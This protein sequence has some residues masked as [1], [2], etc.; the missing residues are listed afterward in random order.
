MVN[1]IVAFVPIYVLSFSLF[2]ILDHFLYNQNNNNKTVL[3]CILAVQNIL[4]AEFFLCVFLLKKH[5]NF[6]KTSYSSVDFNSIFLA[7]EEQSGFLGRTTGLSLS[8][9][10][11]SP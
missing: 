5:Y 4:A 3:H 11:R 8:V 7:M 10:L 2:I 6:A 1:T 9:L